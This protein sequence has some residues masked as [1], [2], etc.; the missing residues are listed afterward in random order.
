MSIKRPSSSPSNHNANLSTTKLIQNNNATP[1]FHYASY[2]RFYNNS[3]SNP[4]AVSTTKPDSISA[5]NDSTPSDHTVSITTPTVISISTP[6]STSTPST[7]STSASIPASVSASTPAEAFVLTHT[8]STV[9]STT[10]TSTSSSTPVHIS[11]AVPTFSSNTT[12]TTTPSVSTSYNAYQVHI[13][14][15]R[16]SRTWLPTAAQAAAPYANASY[17]SI[18]PPPPPAPPRGPSAAEILKANLKFIPESGID[19]RKVERVGPKR[20]KSRPSTAFM[21]K[22]PKVPQVTPTRTV[23]HPWRADIPTIASFS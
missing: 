19:K 18:N 14:S 20:S 2:S 5:T 6:T 8:N 9:P 22:S 17:L 7:A 10:L 23:E 4:N 12:S 13:P 1:D 16:P 11:A 15:T 3:Y 21:P